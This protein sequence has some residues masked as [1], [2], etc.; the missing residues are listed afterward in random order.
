MVLIAV[1]VRARQEFP[2][3]LHDREAFER[4]IRLRLKP[5]VSV[6]FRGGPEAIERILYKWMRCE[7]VREGRLPV[8]IKLDDD[9]EREVLAVRAGGAPAYTVLLSSSWFEQLVILGES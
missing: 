7:L 1:A 9:S 4:F 2:P 5:R 6:E 3:P 8:D